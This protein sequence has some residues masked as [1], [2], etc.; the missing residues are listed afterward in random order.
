MLVIKVGCYP[1]LRKA[2][3]KAFEK[4][5]IAAIICAD[6][7]VT[8][9]DVLCLFPQMV[10]HVGQEIIIEAY[11][12]DNALLQLNAS[13]ERILSETLKGTASRMF[14]RANTQCVLMRV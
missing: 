10:C 8:E 6:I 3:R 13:K 12:T 9:P 1:S 11:D 7:G 14:P 5:M 4:E 2:E